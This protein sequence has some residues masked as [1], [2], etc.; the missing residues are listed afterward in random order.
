MK[1]DRMEQFRYRY[2]L[3]NRMLT[4][5]K[6]DGVKIVFVWAV[7]WAIFLLEILPMLG[8]LILL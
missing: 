1:F 2:A 5:L 4:I 3:W 7:K 8:N 6:N